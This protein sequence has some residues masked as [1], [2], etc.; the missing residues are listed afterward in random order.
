VAWWGSQYR[1]LQ[2]KKVMA[3]AVVGVIRMKGNTKGKT[4]SM[5]PFSSADW[6]SSCPFRRRCDKGGTW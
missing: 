4:E 1:G 6:R 5:E 2:I 3:Q